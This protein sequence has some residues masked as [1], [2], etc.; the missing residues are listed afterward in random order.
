VHYGKEVLEDQNLTIQICLLTG[1]LP[2]AV[3]LVLIIQTLRHIM[4]NMVMV[5]LG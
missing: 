3:V 1:A 5:V 2:V 4:I